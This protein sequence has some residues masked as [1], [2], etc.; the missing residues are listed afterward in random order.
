VL[1]NGGRD[2][3]SSEMAVV[4]RQISAAAANGDPEWSARNNHA[5]KS[6]PKPLIGKGQGSL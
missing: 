3:E 4:G 1:V 5:D 2:D 6:V